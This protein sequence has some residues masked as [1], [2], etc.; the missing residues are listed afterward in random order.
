MNK[1]IQLM[2]EKFTPVFNKITRNIWVSSIQD[3][4]MGVLPLILVGSLMT[5][6]SILKEFIPSVPDFS[7]ISNFSFGFMSLFIAFLL[8]YFV[9]E[10]NKKHD[11]KIISGLAG[12]SLFLMILSPTFTDEGAIAF[13]FERFGANGMF[14]ALSIGLIAAA[15]MLFSTRFSFFKQ[16]S[17]LPDFI[18]VW[19][20][21]IIPITIL[22]AG[23]WLFS[24]VLS[25]DLYNVILGLFEPLSVLGQSF[26]GFVLFTFL[27]IFLYSFG[28]SA[29]A[30]YPIT[31]PIWMAGITT[32]ANAI[33]AGSVATNI[34]TFEVL[35][36]W[37]W[38]GGMGS[39]LTLSLLMLFSAKS[40]HLKAIGSVTTP[41]AIFN[42]N[43][44]MVFG[45]PIAFNPILMIPMWLNGLIIPAITYAV[46]ALDWV[47]IPVKLYQLWYI[48]VGV[49]TYLVNSD[50]RGIFLLLV[51]LAVSALLWWPFFKVYDMQKQK[52][53]SITK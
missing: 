37:V 4:I 18:I 48:P 17:S 49:S 51:N 21:T 34:H 53:E 29:W 30:L 7:P 20:D 22:L 16:S 23:G 36:G 28:I 2:N 45:A 11:R 38:L 6:I 5:M 14:V 19:F 8:P 50:F 52:E 43:E 10:K 13:S 33:A 42:I 3:A 46:F 39:T 26:W 47:S 31:F 32:N 15:I 44:P 35:M 1:L 41:P 9:L 12:V 40:K 25:I 27:G 24:S